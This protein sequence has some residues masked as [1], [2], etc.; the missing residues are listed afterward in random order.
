MGTYVDIQTADARGVSFDHP[1]HN[2]QASFKRLRKPLSA[3]DGDIPAGG[4]QAIPT[5]AS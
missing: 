3:A 5:R 1:T 2:K 4:Q